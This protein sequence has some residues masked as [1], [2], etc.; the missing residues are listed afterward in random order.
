MKQLPPY[1]PCRRGFCAALP[2]LAPGQAHRDRGSKDATRLL[3]QESQP[4]C[5]L[6]L[7][8]PCGCARRRRVQGSAAR[9]RSGSAA[10]GL[11]DHGAALPDKPPVS[12]RCPG[13][14]IGHGPRH[15][16]AWGMHMHVHAY[17]HIYGVLAAVVGA[18]S[19]CSKVVTIV[20]SGR[21][22]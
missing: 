18:L 4:R 13:A 2:L 20:K 15:V 7:A 16:C 10:V 12:P 3:I 9:R 5:R 14:S 19:V 21:Q 22:V 8:W 6:A 17:V 11:P 1:A